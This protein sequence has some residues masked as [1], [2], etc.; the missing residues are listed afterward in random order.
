MSGVHPDQTYAVRAAVTEEVNTAI[1]ATAD[2]PMQSTSMENRAPP[3]GALNM[4]AI[5]ADAPQA[6]ITFVKAGVMPNSRPILLPIAAPAY[7]IG[8]SDPADPPNPNV[9]E[10]ARIGEYV[11]SV[12]RWYL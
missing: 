7:A 3:T 10:L 2:R 1:T 6:I 9:I 4:P 5:P 12:G 8:P 11:R